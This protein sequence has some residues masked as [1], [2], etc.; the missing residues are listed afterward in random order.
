MCFQLIKHDN[1]C[2]MNKSQE[3]AN[4]AFYQSYLFPNYYEQPPIITCMVGAC[5]GWCC[6]W[7]VSTI[8]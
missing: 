1:I 6:K 3:T 5:I 2:S 4:A 8:K 7:V